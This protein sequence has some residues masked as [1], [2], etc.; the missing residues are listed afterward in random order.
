MPGDADFKIGPGFLGI[1]SRCDVDRPGLKLMAFE[2]PVHGLTGDVIP[3]SSGLVV[4]QQHQSVV[5]AAGAEMVQ[6]AV[7]DWGK[8]NPG[9][10]GG[11]KTDQ[12]RF[13]GQFALGA[14][15]VGHLLQQ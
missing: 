2:R 15:M 13:P 8:T 11:S 4:D 5:Q 3:V 10:T 12:V 6:A 1:F 14:V 9:K 7:D